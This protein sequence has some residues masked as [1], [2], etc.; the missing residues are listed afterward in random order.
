MGVLLGIYMVGIALSGDDST[1]QEDIM[2]IV[3]ILHSYCE[4]EE[5]SL[6]GVSMLICMM[7]LE[8]IIKQRGM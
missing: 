8:W 5:G 4:S 2:D 7:V 3:S 6:S 1:G